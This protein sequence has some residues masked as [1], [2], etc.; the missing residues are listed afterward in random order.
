MW[1]GIRVFLIRSLKGG[2]VGRPRP[3]ICSLGGSAALRGAIATIRW[4]VLLPPSRAPFY[5]LLPGWLRGGQGR[6][7]GFAV[8]EV[9]HVGWHC[10][11]YRGE[12]AP[13]LKI[14]AYPLCAG[15]MRGSLKCTKGSRTSARHTARS[16]HVW[17]WQV[18]STRCAAYGNRDLYAG[19]NV[20]IKAFTDGRVEFTRGTQ[21]ANCDDWALTG[22]SLFPCQATIDCLY[23][24]GWQ[25]VC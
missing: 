4:T 13:R 6:G 10:G 1:G 16:R 17:P 19:Y 7:R 25:A 5:E 18:D 9:L 11:R 14:K 12:S 21:V 2:A 24:A 23:K 15:L 8:D 20:C 3:L 22:H